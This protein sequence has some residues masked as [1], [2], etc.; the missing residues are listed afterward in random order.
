MAVGYRSTQHPFSFLGEQVSETAITG[1]IGMHLASSEEIPLAQVHVGLER[2]T[3]DA[4]P[5]SESFFRTTV[6]FRVW[7]R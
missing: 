3:R 5:S 2:G 4:G 1:G 7:G 6:T